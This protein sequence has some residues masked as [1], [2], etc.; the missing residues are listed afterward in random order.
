MMQNSEHPIARKLL[1]SARGLH[2]SRATAGL[3]VTFPGG[4]EHLFF[5]GGELFV[6]PEGS[7]AAQFNGGGLAKVLETMASWSPAAVRPLDMPPQDRRLVGPLPTARLLMEGFIR[8]RSEDDL[9]EILG[10]ERAHLVAPPVRSTGAPALDPEDAFLLSR[11]EHPAAL[12]DILYQGTMDRRTILQRLGRLRAVEL[13]MPA[14]SVEAGGGDDRN[15]L[16]SAGLL[17]RLLDRLG[18]DLDENPLGLDRTVHR[19][20]VAQLLARC[21]GMTHY[22]LLNVGLEAGDDQIHRAFTEF[23]RL[24]HP[25]HAAPLSLAGREAALQL[26]FERGARAYLTLSDP[27]RRASYNLEMGFSPGQRGESERAEER[28]LEG[29]RA[30]EQAKELAATEDF[31]FAIELLRQAVVLDPQPEYYT[32]LGTCQLRNPNWVHHALDSAR[33]GLRLRSTDLPLHILLAQALEA[34]GELDDAA[35]EYLWVCDRDPEQ[36]KASEGLGRIA[37]TLGVQVETYLKKMRSGRKT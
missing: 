28:K 11:L 12:G 17:S 36:V 15:A 9:I 13:V 7:V 31:H 1:E 16:L 20:R 29:R 35:Q 33:A 23:G 25:S 30:Y 10:G 14:S 18:A 34:L 19:V 5:R 37:S 4:I 3:E 26:L 8:G 24:V 27:R 21:G 22:E 32:L 2:L 6:P